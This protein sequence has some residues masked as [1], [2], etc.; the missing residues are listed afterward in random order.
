MSTAEDSN[1]LATVDDIHRRLLRPPSLNS[2]YD[3]HEDRS[4]SQSKANSTPIHRKQETM[5]RKLEDYL[6]PVF[7]DDSRAETKSNEAV[8]LNDGL[9]LIV[10]GGETD[11]E[12]EFCTPFRRYELSALK[13]FR[14]ERE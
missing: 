5:K 6:D 10:D 7:I 9:D 2:P 14:R 13:R 12:D 3:D 1:P 8:N 4:S 11:G